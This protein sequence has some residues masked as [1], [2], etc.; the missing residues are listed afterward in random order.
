MHSVVS[1]DGSLYKV[2]M[3]SEF[4]ETNEEA[5]QREAKYQMFA[6]TLTE[7]VPKIFSVDRD[8]IEMEPIKGETL[9]KM[10][11]RL[12]KKR[13]DEVKDDVY[14]LIR[15]FNSN[16][17]YH[18]DLHPSNIIIGDS[19]SVYIIDFGSAWNEPIFHDDKISFDEYLN[20]VMEHMK[21][22]PTLYFKDHGIPDWA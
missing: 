9:Q 7:F 22:Y 19:G 17:L 5:A 16:G 14:K 20:E 6:S 13:I 4:D 1:I 11:P 18:Q 15:L 3:C 21:C 12:G 10:L 2:I 8:C